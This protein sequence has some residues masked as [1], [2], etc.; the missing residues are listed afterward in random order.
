MICTS[1]QYI[2]LLLLLV[3]THILVLS[4]TKM[5]TKM[6]MHDHS[7]PTTHTRTLLLLVIGVTSTNK[8]SK[9]RQA[10]VRF[11][12]WGKFELPQ[13]PKKIGWSSNP[14]IQP[15]GKSPKN[16]IYHR[17]SKTMT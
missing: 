17:G 3:P 1:K 4:A 9:T 6:F 7:K 10:D 2:L 12:I 8:P 14:T 5:K 13:Q 11:F 16:K 15:I